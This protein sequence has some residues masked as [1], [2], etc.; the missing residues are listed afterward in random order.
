ME[1]KFLKVKICRLQL[2]TYLSRIS[3]YLVLS[4]MT[5]YLEIAILLAKTITKI[6]N[7]ILSIFLGPKKLN[8]SQTSVCSCWL[9]PVASVPGRHPFVVSYNISNNGDFLV[10]WRERVDSGCRRQDVRS[11]R[12][13]GWRRPTVCR[14]VSVCPLEGV[15][16]RGHPGDYL[17]P[18]KWLRRIWPENVVRENQTDLETWSAEVWVCNLPPPPPSFTTTCTR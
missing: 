6:V 12:K 14:Y 16:G 8:T 1:K 9:W 3:Y 15:L 4:D 7:Q 2:K 18:R 17:W 11:I 5:H 13:L 10:W